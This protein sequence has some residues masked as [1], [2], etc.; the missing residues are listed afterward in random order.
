MRKRETKHLF[1]DNPHLFQDNPDEWTAMDWPSTSTKIPR[2]AGGP[3][4]PVERGRRRARLRGLG[5]RPREPVVAYRARG[6]GG[7]HTYIFTPSFSGRA[8]NTVT[9]GVRAPWSKPTGRAPKSAACQSNDVHELAIK[10]SACAS[11]IGATLAVPAAAYC[12]H[13]HCTWIP[14]HT[15]ARARTHTVMSMC[16]H[17][18]TSMDTD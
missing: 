7:P 5:P 9:I 15:H 14:T 3:H 1:Q 4:R 8:V 16:I 17:I 12:W 18:D 10:V 11:K 13:C 6:A 2:D